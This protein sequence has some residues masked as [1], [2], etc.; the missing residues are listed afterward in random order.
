MEYLLQCRLLEML[1]ILFQCS[2]SNN[3]T[4]QLNEESS[5]ETFEFTYTCTAYRNP[6]AIS[7]MSYTEFWVPRSRSFSFIFCVASKTQFLMAS[8][9][10]KLMSSFGNLKLRNRPIFSIHL[11]HKIMFVITQLYTPQLYYEN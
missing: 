11:L 5:L 2:Q 4:F 6:V 3:S 8:L 9:K 1:K 10:T 7:H